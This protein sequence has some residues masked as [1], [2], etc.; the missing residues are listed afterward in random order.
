MF[1]NCSLDVPNVSTLRKHSANIPGILLPAG[2]KLKAN[3][4]AAFNNQ[5]F[6]VYSDSAVHLIST[7]KKDHAFFIWKSSYYAFWY[8]PF[9]LR[10]Y[11]C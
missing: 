6:Q 11:T 1:P 4:M 3:R 2:L 5:C 7:S 8:R 10:S 9:I